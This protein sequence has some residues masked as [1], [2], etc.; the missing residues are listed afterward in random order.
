MNKQPMQVNLLWTGREYYSL[1]NCFVNILPS[2]AD[3]TSTI[4]G[5]YE[6]KIYKIDYGI[7]TNQDWE[8]LQ[9]NIESRHTNGSQSMR[10]QSD[11]KGN[12]TNEGKT[13]DQFQGCTDIDI[14]LTPLT[15]T[16]PIRRLRLTPNQFKEIKV[17]YFDPLKGEIRP[18]RQQYTCLSRT[19]YRYENVPNDFESV[20]E[21][22]EAG[23]VVDYPGLFV[24]TAVAHTKHV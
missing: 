16:L 11:G 1:E 13:V 9:V 6:D 17:L 21:V 14:T 15:N 10:L 2:G 3:I 24:R 8:T 20:I 7:K 19:K 18:V 5:H 22:D 12:W 23:L 4:V